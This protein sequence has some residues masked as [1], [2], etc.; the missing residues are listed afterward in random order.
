MSEELVVLNVL[1]VLSVWPG[2]VKSSNGVEINVMNAKFRVNGGEM[3]FRV[4]DGVEVPEHWEGRAFC[5]AKIINYK[6]TWNNQTS[7]RFAVQPYLVRRFDKIKPVE[8]TSMIDQIFA[9]QVKTNLK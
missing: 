8:S 9:P 6:H 2:K 4:A 1:E 5:D 7:I 3:S